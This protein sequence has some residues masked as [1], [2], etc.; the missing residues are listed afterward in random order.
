MDYLDATIDSMENS[1]F[2]AVYGGLIRELVGISH[3][4]QT[5]I[6]CLLMVYYKFAKVN[7]PN[8]KKMTKIQFY[9]LFLVLFKV[10][11]VQ[12]IDRTLFAVTKDVKYVSPQ[13]W[14]QLFSLYTTKDLSVRMRFA[15]DIY[16]TKATGFIDREQVSL[17]CEKFFTGEDE[18]EITE[19]RADMGEFIIKK[20]DVDK[21][22]LISFEDYS[23]V[24]SEQPCLLEFLGRLFPSPEDREIMAHCINMDS[25]L[26]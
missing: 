7:G 6:N 9:Q 15:F 4:S 10:S 14:V 13:A 18:D 12:T 8:A 20:F 23:A 25:I 5:D 11:N 26:T 24:V 17:A 3:L 1:R 19:L 22:G 21:D 16:D 2:V